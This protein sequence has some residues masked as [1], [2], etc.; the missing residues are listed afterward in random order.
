MFL[1]VDIWELTKSQPH[2]KSFSVVYD[3][4]HCCGITEKES[5]SQM[6]LWFVNDHI[7]GK[8]CFLRERDNEDQQKNVAET[9]H[10]PK[11]PKDL[12][13]FS[14]VSSRTISSSCDLNHSGGSKFTP[15]HLLYTFRV[16]ISP[17]LTDQKL[18]VILAT[19]S[20]MYGRFGNPCVFWAY[21]LTP[22]QSRS[23]P[24]IWPLTFRRRGWTQVR[25]GRKIQGNSIVE[26]DTFL[27]ATESE[28][29]K[30]YL[31]YGIRISIFI[32]YF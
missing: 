8:A 12:M 11:T 21:I 4:L 9:G 17:F 32:I 29:N 3:C 24:G 2:M 26:V 14:G 16:M 20:H 25:K 10:F 1:N 7:I 27:S 5:T 23:E 15:K 6:A 28:T 19:D 31:V 30:M 18:C 22:Y 13:V